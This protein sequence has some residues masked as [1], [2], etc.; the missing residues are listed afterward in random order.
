MPSFCELDGYTI[1]E[2]DNLRHIVAGRIEKVAVFGGRNRS[3]GFGF[4]P[5]PFCCKL[6]RALI[7]VERE[8]NEDIRCQIV[9]CRDIYHQRRK[10]A[11]NRASRE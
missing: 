1:V 10:H 7:L 4:I 8:E 6:G 5:N 11:C 2:I 9:M 3:L